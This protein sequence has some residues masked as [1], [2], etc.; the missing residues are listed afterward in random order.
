[1]REGGWG[2][3]VVGRVDPRG[4]GLGYFMPDRHMAPPA[5]ATFAATSPGSAVLVCLFSDAAARSGDW[6]DLGSLPGWRRDEWPVPRFVR[7]DAVRGQVVVQYDEQDLVTPSSEIRASV[8][9]TA[10]FPRDDLFGSGAVEL[11]LTALT[12]RS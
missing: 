4:V 2:I 3:G 12:R 5:V 6:I 8:T 9:D 1:L 10:G 11:A 7:R